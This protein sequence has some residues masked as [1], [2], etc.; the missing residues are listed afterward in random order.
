MAGVVLYFGCDSFGTSGEI[1]HPI[2]D[3][4]TTPPSEATV[5]LSRGGGR[6]DK[7]STGPVVT[8]RERFERREVIATIGGMEGTEEGTFGLLWDAAIT[9][10]DEVLILDRIQTNV[11]VF[12]AT[13]EYLYTLGGQGEGPGELQ[14]PEALVLEPGG[15]LLVADQA[16]LIHRFARRGDRFEYYDRSRFEG[17]PRDACWVGDDLIV[18]GMR[19]GAGQQILHRTATG[20]QPELSFA[21]PYRYAPSLVYEMLS[22]GQVACGVENGGWVVIAYRL[23]NAIEAYDIVDGELLWNARIDGLRPT[24][25][26][27][28]RGGRSVTTGI[29]GDERALHFLRRVAGGNGVPVFVQYS[30]SLREDI[31]NQTGHHTVE[32]YVLDPETGEGEYWGDSIPS[33][34]TVTDEYAVSYRNDPYPRVRVARI[35]R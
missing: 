1:V 7:G 8:F 30:Y 16:Q 15:D 6:A 34:L 3:S 20:R 28:R 25:A 23:R 29:F 5:V 9:A 4:L 22:R 35:P 10:A 27:E 11:R 24:E 13:G 18:H 26:R 17:E 32:T 2:V 21:V 14:V 33:L 12:S 31:L 19:S